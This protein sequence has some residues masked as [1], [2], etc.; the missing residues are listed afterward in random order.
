MNT[1]SQLTEALRCA[2]EH[3]DRGIVGLVDDLLQLCPKDGLRLDWQGDRAR[4]QIP[5]ARKDEMM[6]LAIPRSALRAILARIAVL[7]NVQRA[8]SVSPYGGQG[9][10]TAGTHGQAGFRVSFTNTAAEQRLELTSAR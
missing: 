8:N 3:P 7:C 1:T 10:L 4:L 9:E 5:N 2:F 6:D